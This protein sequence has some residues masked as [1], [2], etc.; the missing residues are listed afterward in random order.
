M[1]FRGFLI[2]SY[3]YS[4]EGPQHPILMIK[5][6]IL[7]L[8][9]QATEAP[10]AEHLVLDHTVDDINV[11]PAVPIIIYQNSHSLGSLR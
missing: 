4:I 10:S 2:I 7:G 3:N 8:D 5:A 1:H 9:L 11:N 6:P